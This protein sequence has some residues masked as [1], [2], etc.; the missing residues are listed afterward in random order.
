MERVFR[1]PL[2]D[3]SCQTCDRVNELGWVYACTMDRESAAATAAAAAAEREKIMNGDMNTIAVDNGEPGEVKLSDWIV[4][5]I[6]AGHYTEAEIEILKAQKATV[7]NNVA[8][9]RNETKSKSETIESSS[10]SSLTSTKAEPGENADESPPTST[11]RDPTG[12]LRTLLKRTF[13]KRPE[14]IKAPLVHPCNMQRCH[15]CFSVGECRTWSSLDQVCSPDFDLEIVPSDIYDIPDY[16]V[17]TVDLYA[18]Y[19]KQNFGVGGFMEVYNPLDHSDSDSSTRET[20]GSVRAPPWLG[21]ATEEYWD[22]AN[23][24]YYPRYDPTRPSWSNR[25]SWGSDS[26]RWDDFDEENDNVDDYEEKYRPRELT[27]SNRASW[28]SD[29]D[30]PSLDAVLMGAIGALANDQGAAAEEEAGNQSART[31]PDAHEVPHCDGVL[32]DKHD[33]ISPGSL[34]TEPDAG[35]EPDTRKHDPELTPDAPEPESEVMDADLEADILHEDLP[36]AQQ[37]CEEEPEE[38]T[39]VCP[40]FPFPSTSSESSDDACAREA[41][42][43]AFGNYQKQEL[44]TPRKISRGPNG[45]ATIDEGEENR[46]V[47]EMRGR[48]R[49]VRKPGWV[50]KSKGK[51]EAEM[52]GDG[53]GECINKGKGKA[54]D[55]LIAEEK[56]LNMADV[57]A[58]A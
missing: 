50:V 53:V 24:C 18:V 38:E 21:P 49:L 10:T 6:E 1:S 58:Q 14:L 3:T 28:G 15:M 32:E 30:T 40:P 42:Y 35:S 37:E 8:K 55:G 23:N 45:L 57:S 22:R 46:P 17:P 39:E 41:L 12:C 20:W 25:A 51:K 44:G 27:H 7:Q 54:K 34:N 9:A 29:V 5:A 33:D 36:F 56:G 2:E 47:G 19:A 31:N 13:K 16:D 43:A 11:P 52:E 4:K 26:Y 48:P